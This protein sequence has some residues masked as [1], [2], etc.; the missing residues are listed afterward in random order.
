MATEKQ[1][2]GA[3]TTSVPKKTLNLYDLHPVPRDLILGNVSSSNLIVIAL[4]SEEHLNWIRGYFAR[5][6]VLNLKPYV[7]KF[8]LSFDPCSVCNMSCNSGKYPHRIVRSTTTMKKFVELGLLNVNTICIES[9]TKPKQPRCALHG[10]KAICD[11]FTQGIQK[12]FF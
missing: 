8:C 4:F 2:V 9:P 10:V 11:F 12:V 1:N 5:F 7:N 3:S 6:K